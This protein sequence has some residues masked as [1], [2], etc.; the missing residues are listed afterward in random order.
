MGHG[1]KEEKKLFRTIPEALGGL[2]CEY[3]YLRT[4]PREEKSDPADRIRNTRQERKEE[5][6]QRWREGEKYKLACSKREGNH[7]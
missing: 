6:L 7:D 4:V 1:I 3:L 2:R 5:K